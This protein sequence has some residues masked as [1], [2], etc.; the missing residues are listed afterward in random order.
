MKLRRPILLLTE[1]I[2]LHAGILSHLVTGETISDKNKNQTDTYSPTAFPEQISVADPGSRIRIF[3]I[4]DPGSTRFQIFIKEF[5]YLSFFFSSRKYD[6]ICSSR[7]RILIFYPSRIPGSKRHRIPD[8]QHCEQCTGTHW[9]PD[10]D[11]R[12][13]GRRTW[14]RI[15]CVPEAQFMVV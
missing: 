10:Q 7:I 2:A 4:P 13:T 15:F 12:F 3:Y 8:P 11:N 14:G 9:F 1:A 6:P 5:K